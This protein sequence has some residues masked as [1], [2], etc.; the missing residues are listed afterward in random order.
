MFGVASMLCRLG[1]RPYLK[2]ALASRVVADFMATLAYMNYERDGYLSSYA[3]DPVLTFG[4][5]KVWY[6]LGNGLFKFILP[7]L[8]KLILDE[9]LDTGGVG[10]MVARILLLLAMDKCAMISPGNLDDKLIGQL[11]P[12]NKFL[13]ELGVGKMTI[14]YKGGIKAP[15]GEKDAFK[16]WQK[17]WDGWHMGFTHFVQLVREPDEDTLWYLLG[18]RA[19]GVFPRGQHGADLLIPMVKR[20]SDSESDSREESDEEATE[21]EISLMLVQVG[22]CFQDSEVSLCTTKEFAF[23]FVFEAGNSLSKIAVDD[24]I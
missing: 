12:V 19:A 2:S 6:A 7:Q 23:W 1:I 20:K 3:S 10:E 24:V 21:D 16:K 4:A 11:V 5:I 22:N 17:K 8:K 9:T 14:Y 18:R 13:E 15:D